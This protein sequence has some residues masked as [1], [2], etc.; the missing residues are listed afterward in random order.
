MATKPFNT[1]YIVNDPETAGGR[2]VLNGSQISKITAK[3]NDTGWQ[4]TF[5]MADGA[6]YSVT[7]DWSA[8]FVKETFG[9]E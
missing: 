5:H 6:E 2:I 8:N 4:V 3:K 1:N 7:N 9:Q